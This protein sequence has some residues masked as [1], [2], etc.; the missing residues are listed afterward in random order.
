[1]P[2]LIGGNAFSAPH[3]QLH[4][5][6]ENFPPRVRLDAAAGRLFDVA[7]LEP[8]PAATSRS[9]RAL[10]LRPRPRAPRRASALQGRP[11]VIGRQSGVRGRRRLRQH[12]RATSSDFDAP[13]RGAGGRWVSTTARVRALPALVRGRA[14]PRRRHPPALRERPR[15]D[16]HR[17]PRGCRSWTVLD[18]RPAGRHSAF[19]PSGSM[20]ACPGAPTPGFPARGRRRCLT[21]DEVRP[22]SEQA[23]R[24]TTAHPR[25]RSGQPLRPERRVHHRGDR[26]GRRGAG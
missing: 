10:P 25:R 16:L 1:M 18:R 5:A 22:S 19:V 11:L 14:H 8:R 21:A 24:Q 12:Q 15:R 7:V 20:P 6:G 26:P 23:A 3:R 17:R 2:A 9:A 13:R 4:R